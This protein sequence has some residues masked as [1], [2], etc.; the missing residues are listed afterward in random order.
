M[1]CSSARLPGRSRTIPGNELIAR[2]PRSRAQP[3]A[4]RKSLELRTEPAGT[5]PALPSSAHIGY[6]NRKMRK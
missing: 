6:P 2:F 3:F 5:G 1:S 4:V